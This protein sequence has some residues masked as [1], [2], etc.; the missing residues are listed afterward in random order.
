MRFFWLGFAIG[1]ALFA[2]VLVA[3][4]LG[5]GRDSILT[6]PVGPNT[7]YPCGVGWYVCPNSPPAPHRSCCLEG[8]ACGGDAG[9]NVPQ[10][11]PAGQCCDEQPTP[12]ARRDGG[13][14]SYE[15]RR[16]DPLRP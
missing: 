11:C 8:D 5:C 1:W 7:S 15:Q 9:P 10:T 13:A 12:E 14:R 16:E 6:P 3:H 4:L 2:V